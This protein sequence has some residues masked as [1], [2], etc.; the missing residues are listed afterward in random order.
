MQ[1][2]VLNALLIITSLFGYLEWGGNNRIFLFK[3]EAEIF[4]K[5]FTNPSSALH[6]LTILPILGQLLLL[7]TIFQ[8]V[9]NK[10]LIY[11]GIAGLGLLLSLM[12][13]AGLVSMNLKIIISTIPFIVVSILAIRYYNK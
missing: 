10:T 12:F 3:A 11:I 1:S 5:F 9:P 6:P 8:K 7:I 2:K 4:S 13:I